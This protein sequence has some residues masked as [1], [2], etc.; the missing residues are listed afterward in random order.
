[1]TKL[2][3][4]YEKLQASRITSMYKSQEQLQLETK[5]SLDLLK[6]E[7]IDIEKG[8]EGSRG[9]KVIGH[10]KSGKPIYE[11]HEQEHTQHY[12]AEDH[13][14][15]VTHHMREAKKHSDEHREHSNM[16]KQDSSLS[17]SDEQRERFETRERSSRQKM[18]H[19]SSMAQLHSQAMNA[20]M[21]KKA[22]EKK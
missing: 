12:T 6:G 17:L 19:H 22:E 9:G 7:T 1:M 14:D 4:T 21:D 2:F 10:T 16:L 3:S 20:K 18:E 8:G 5:N 15:A 11:H 13:S